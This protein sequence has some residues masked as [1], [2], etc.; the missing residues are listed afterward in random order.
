MLVQHSHKLTQYSHYQK[1][2]RNIAGRT[3]YNGPAQERLRFA[4]Y[5]IA[6]S[7]A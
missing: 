5:R 6:V 2:Q 7:R 4:T 3:A 1:E